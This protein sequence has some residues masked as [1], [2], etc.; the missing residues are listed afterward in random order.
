MEEMRG[1]RTRENEVAYGIIG[2]NHCYISFQIS[3]VVPFNLICY[4]RLHALHPHTFSG[5]VRLLEY[6]L[7]GLRVALH[8]YWVLSH[9]GGFLGDI[10]SPISVA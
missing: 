4:L 1:S 3:A 9:F 8:W 10:A 2:H 5:T 6:F 7:S